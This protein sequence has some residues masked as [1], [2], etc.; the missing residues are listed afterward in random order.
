MN[1]YHCPSLFEYVGGRDA[2]G[3]FIYLDDNSDLIRIVPG[4]GTELDYTVVLDGNDIVALLRL[5]LPIL[6]QENIAE[7]AAMQLPLSPDAA[8]KSK[9][10]VQ[11]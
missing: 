7:I 4:P 3:G 8:G 5:A 6:S 2:G 11:K 9:D 1:A 10:V